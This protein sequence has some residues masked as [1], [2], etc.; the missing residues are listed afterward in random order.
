MTNSAARHARFAAMALLAILLYRGPLLTLYR[1]ALHN[2]TYTHILLVPLVSVFFFWTER[3]RI[4]R[5]GYGS[6]MAAK[7]AGFIMAVAATA[8]FT[9]S[10]SMAGRL[11]ENDLLSLKI[12]SFIVVLTGIFIATYGYRVYRRALFPSLFLLFM[13]PFPTLLLDRSIAFLQWGSKEL[14]YD[15]LSLV[16]VPILK[17]G[18]VF[19]LPGITIEVA[20]ECSGIR[21]S[22]A[23]FLTALIAGHMFL[24]RP[25]AKIILLVLVV[26]FVIIKN[27][28]R[29]ST[30]ALLAVYVDKR[31]ITDSLLHHEGGFVFFL[32]ALLLMFPFLVLLRKYE[33]KPPLKSVSRKAAKLA[34]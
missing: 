23:L 4:F 11:T 20:R 2:E 34:K 14:S 32:I 6:S 12:L 9:L 27:S 18:Y 17:S 15:I 3:N 21:S 30:L 22:I 16:G 8:A 7:V 10:G 29:I 33:V 25:R 1:T 31:W 26:P 5:G 13:V 28:V 24:K 19:Q